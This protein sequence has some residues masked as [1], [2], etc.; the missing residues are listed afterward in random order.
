M[1]NKVGYIVVGAAMLLL[2]S[3]SSVEKDAKKAASLVNKSIEQSLA[4]KFED[5]EKTY[6]KAQKIINK[7]ADEDKTVEFYKHYANYRDKEK[8]QSSK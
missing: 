6:L 4:L 5:A 8:K 7:Y 2:I 3:C 1:I